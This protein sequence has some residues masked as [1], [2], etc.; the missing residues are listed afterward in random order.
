MSKDSSKNENVKLFS[1]LLESIK[2]SVGDSHQT[3]T[4][5]DLLSNWKAFQSTNEGELYE[6]IGWGLKNGV[7]T[8]VDGK[9]RGKDLF[10]FSRDPL[11]II[12]SDESR[13]IVSTPPVSEFGLQRA[14]SRYDFCTTRESFTEIIKSAR[15]VLRISS[16]FFERNI[17]EDDAFPEF[18]TLLSS[19]LDRGCELRI[20]SRQ[21]SAKRSS[22]L[23]WLIQLFRK[24]G[25]IDQVRLFDYHIEDSGHSI[26]SSIH[27]K[28]LIADYSVAYVGSAE[29]RRNSISKNFEV[30]A[31]I[32]GPS[33]W[34]LVELFDLMTAYSKELL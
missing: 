33:V 16:P 4:I 9:M 22:D 13:I 34:G 17:I 23:N 10:R 20:V 19:A 32:K 18:P 26:V 28:M 24:I 5:G 6:A 3:F 12:S 31:L 1:K 8:K 7:L 2:Q 14:L 30:G 29:I 27:A 21:I 11:S 25:K 15:E